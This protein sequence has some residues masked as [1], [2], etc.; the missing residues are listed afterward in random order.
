MDAQSF[1]KGTFLE[2]L[3]NCAMFVEHMLSAKKALHKRMK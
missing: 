3:D 1:A 2:F